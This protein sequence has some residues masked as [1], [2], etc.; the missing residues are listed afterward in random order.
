MSTMGRAAALMTAGLLLGAGS[1]QAQ[2]RLS[3][4]LRVGSNSFADDLGDAELESGFGFD[5]SLAVRLYEHLWAY[6]GWGWH[7]F[8]TDFALWGADSS[9]EQTGYRLGLRWE[10]PVTDQG[11]DGPAFWV[12]AGGTWEHIEVE[13]DA[14]DLVTDSDLG[15]GW[16]AGGGVSFPA[17]AGWRLTPGVRYRALSRELAFG[18]LVPEVLLEYLALE[19]GVSRTF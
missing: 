1:L 19:L 17:W 9:V 8:D 10:H 5:G 3:V 13:D 6:G 7:G 4:D 15:E 12:H 18:E 16:E 14:G 2:D 11:R